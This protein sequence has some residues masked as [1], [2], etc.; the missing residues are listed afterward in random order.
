MRLS[1]NPT[2]RLRLWT[3]GT[4][5]RLLRKPTMA[6]ISSAEGSTGTTTAS[7]ASRK[8]GISSAIAP[9][10]ASMMTSSVP[11]GTSRSQLFLRYTSIGSTALSRTERRCAQRVLEPCGSASA[12]TVR[13]PSNAECAARWVA[14]VVLPTPPLEPATRIVFMQAS[15]PGNVPAAYTGACDGDSRSAEPEPTATA[16]LSWVV[17]MD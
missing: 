7:A 17:P 16:L 8:C 11:S 12:R 5:D 1:T 14:T 15:L 6:S 10:G 2:G 4:R 13:L 3:R 9:A